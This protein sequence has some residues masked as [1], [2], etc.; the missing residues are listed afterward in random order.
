MKISPRNGRPSMRAVPKPETKFALNAQKGCTL[1]KKML[2][3][4]IVL[5]LLFCANAFALNGTNYPA[6]DGASDPIDGLC[7]NIDGSNLSLSFDP[8]ADYSLLADGMAQLCFFAFDAAEQNYIEMY[9]LLPEDAASGDVF[10]PADG[11][12]SS[13]SLYEVSQ[14]REDV[15]FAGQVAGIAYPDGASYELSLEKVER[16][17][18]TL[19]MS[20]TLNG[21]LVRFSDD[22]PTGETLTLS[23]LRFNFSLPLSDT[24]LPENT[25][26]PRDDEAPEPSLSPLPSSSPVQ[27]PLPT[28]TAGSALEPHPAFTLPP[29][30]AEL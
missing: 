10:S 12:V 4:S 19:N 28:S 21:T 9:L 7:G 18:S 30:Y 23:N 16:S 13:V 2:A 24:I 22:T 15:Y 29:D 6:W 20:G 1:M 8:S 11:S 14:S 26:A 3:A 17:S 5:A 27:T 25:V